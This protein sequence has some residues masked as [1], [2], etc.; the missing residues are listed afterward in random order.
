MRHP[1]RPDPETATPPGIAPPGG[2]LRRLILGPPLPSETEAR[3]RLSN[4]TA[5][6][7]LSSDALS[8][9]AYATEEIL[10]VLVPVAGVAAFGLSL[11]IGAAIIVLLG[12]L[13]LSYR[14]TIKAYPSA[15][16]AYIVTRDN[17]GLV[18][19]QAAGVAL[20]LDYIMTVAVSIA[21][22][23]AALYS[24]FPVLY[25]LRL[26]IAVS[27]IWII[28]WGN[29]RGLRATGKLFAAPTYVFLA[30]IAGMV[31]AGLA[32]ALRGGLHPIPPPPGAAL[33]SAGAVGWL[34][35][36]HAYASGTTALTG[37]EAISNGVPVFRPP[38]W[39]NARRVLTWM[40]SILALSFGSIT[41]LAWKLHPVPTE[42]KTVVSEIGGAVFGRGAAGRAAL[43]VLQVATTVI[44]VLAANTSFQD[45][46]RLASFHA[47][48]GYL[49]KPLRR[50][51]S[52]L[53]FSTGIVSLAVLAT[54]VIVV[55]GADVHRLIPLYAVGVFASFTFSQSGM[56]V[57]HLRLREEGWRRGVV[58]NAAGAVGSG[59]AL[60]AILV[61]KF[62]HG[63]WVVAILVPL[64]VGLFL[65]IHRH[66]ERAEAVLSSPGS[67]ATAWR[68]LRLLVACDPSDAGLV[69]TAGALVRRIE[70]GE[71]AGDPQASTSPIVSPR[72]AGAILEQA[73]DDDT[74]TLLVL[75]RWAGRRLPAA[76]SR[77]GLLRRRALRLSHVAVATATLDREHS[78]GDDE[79]HEAL[80]LVSR[81]NGLSRL[82]L[83]VA[84]ALAP[85][86]VHALH[87]AIEQEQVAQVLEQ[88]ERGGSG[89]DLE[90][91]G[92]P[93]REPGGPLRSK[94]E[95]L[96]G[97]GVALVS[98]VV[99]TLLLRWW[100]RPL[101]ENS[102]RPI[103]AALGEV[104]NTA[105][106]ECRFPLD[107][108]A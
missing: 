98:V 75:P 30:A 38:E 18:P 26:P 101:Y 36:V 77:T 57:R 106:V 23:A 34:L 99:P 32:S 14:Q 2:R 96:R 4:P 31:A 25:A 100:Q 72:S 90:V 7:I 87:I 61:A 22:A 5:L 39:R 58:I 40:G 108:R 73:T 44:L 42:R 19:A 41:L 105:V 13:I 55:V 69:T 24:Y 97:Q 84:R 85:D 82:A 15:G 107:R 17:F 91:V 27:F 43:L 3:E 21:A 102:T 66:Y 80:A 83:Q 9:V 64:D 1:A 16:G 104:A 67:G 35:L 52:R 88:W 12:L 94:V 59:L 70:R 60:L 81:P 65:Q 45:F 29:L 48:D 50:R 93:W 103:R 28:A 53:V 49:P 37:V 6:A 78:I 62:T 63:A 11:P 79:R 46:P 92:A 68:R 89:V 56:T 76:W 71:G 51:G 20:L 74:L 54:L 33:R 47:G 95:A 86:E 8:S 10:R